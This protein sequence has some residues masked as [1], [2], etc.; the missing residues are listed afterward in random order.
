M[1]SLNVTIVTVLYLLTVSKKID[2]YYIR[3]AL[4]YLVFRQACSTILTF[5]NLILYFIA[6]NT[7]NY[8]EQSFISIPTYIIL[9]TT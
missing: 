9:S 5:N 8:S 2:I 1:E 7:K 6:S 3:K 4:P